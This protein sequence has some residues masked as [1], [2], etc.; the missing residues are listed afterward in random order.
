MIKFDL[1]GRIGIERVSNLTFTLFSQALR[2]DTTR[3]L[4][5]VSLNNASTFGEVPGERNGKPSEVCSK[6]SGARTAQE[7]T[8]S[9][10]RLSM[11]CKE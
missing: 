9:R 2:R 3:R 4:H 5:E 7:K 10:R 11:L 6:G 8:I 1:F